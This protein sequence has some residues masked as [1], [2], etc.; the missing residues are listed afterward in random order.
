MRLPKLTYEQLDER[1]KAAYDK[2]AERRDVVRGP[3]YVWLHSPQM[4]EKVSAMANY[5]RFDCHLPVRLREFGI[6][7]T[8]R[9]WDAQYSWNAHV[10]KAI[11]AGVPEAVVHDLAAGRRPSFTAEDERIYYD[12]ATELLEQHFV[13]DET[14]AEAQAMFGNEA[15]VDLIGSI[16]YWSMLQMCLNSAEVDLQ[17]D[18][19]PP[20]PDLAGYRKIR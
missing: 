6:L 10:D 8:A 11:A 13:S 16:G 1:Q 9:H 17:A 2:H 5:L 18:R 14:F 7:V 12:F 19:P 15:L 20:F 4:M 3:Y